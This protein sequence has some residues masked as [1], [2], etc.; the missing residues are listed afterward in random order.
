MLVSYR[1]LSPLFQFSLSADTLVY[2][3]QWSYL[4]ACPV[5]RVRQPGDPGPS[6]PDHRTGCPTAARGAAAAGRT[7]ADWRE[8]AAAGFHTSPLPLL[9]TPE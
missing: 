6:C 4:K 1:R 8:A 7:A 3:S 5:P 2:L 9:C